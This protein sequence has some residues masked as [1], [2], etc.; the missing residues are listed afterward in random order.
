MEKRNPQRLKKICGRQNKIIEEFRIPDRFINSE[1]VAKN[2]ELILKLIEIINQK[3]FDT[4][5]RDQQTLNDDLSKILTI[6]TKL[7]T[8]IWRAQKKMISP[9]SK[10]PL[11]EYKNSFRHLESGMSSL[12]LAGIKMIDPTGKQYMPGTSERVLAFETKKE[13]EKE[14][15]IETVRP[16]IYYKKE[17]IQQAEIIVGTPNIV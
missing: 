12:E 1:L 15:V 2:N 17:L 3:D 8:G 4:Q 9:N 11:P 13:L 7:I 14:I 10:E 6:L 5:S 16:S